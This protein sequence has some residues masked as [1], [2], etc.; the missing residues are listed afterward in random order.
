MFQRFVTTATHFLIMLCLLFWV[1]FS[2][3]SDSWVRNST[4]SWK[5]L[6]QIWNSQFINSTVRWRM[7]CKD[8][9]LELLPISWILKMHVSDWFAMKILSMISEPA[10]KCS[11]F[12][13]NGVTDAWYCV[14]NILTLYW[15][16]LSSRNLLFKVFPKNLMDRMNTL[17]RKNGVTF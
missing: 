5:K 17:E 1:K 9:G 11:K 6:S 15:K 10:I 16:W 12:E 8:M 4:P 14:H 7:S 13:V 3:W 2:I